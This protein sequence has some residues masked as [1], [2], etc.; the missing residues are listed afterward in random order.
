M[1][2]PQ[3]GSRQAQ[4]LDLMLKQVGGDGFAGLD[5]LLLPGSRQS[6][7]TPTDQVAMSLAALCQHAS[8]RE[9]VE[10]LMDITIRQNM[11]TGGKTLE[12]MALVAKQKQTLD[13]VANAV[14]AAIDHGRTLSENRS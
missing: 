9:I 12:E 4:P 3:F 14:L 6:P 5:K 1:S 10:W 8:G 13:M 11:G 7:L 2:G